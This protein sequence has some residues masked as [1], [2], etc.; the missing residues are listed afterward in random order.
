MF[1]CIERLVY[2]YESSRK[3]LAHSSLTGRSEVEV[4]GRFLTKTDRR[5]QCIRAILW[6]DIVSRFKPNKVKISVFIFQYK[7]EACNKKWDNVFEKEE[8]SNNPL[9]GVSISNSK[10]LFTILLSYQLL[11]QHVNY[12]W[13]HV[14]SLYYSWKYQTNFLLMMIVINPFNHTF[15]LSS[16]I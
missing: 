16:L 12:L 15:T 11:S 3:A 10:I 1:R 4:L 7:R 13:N 5:F 14:I 2:K 9:F 6:D 8:P